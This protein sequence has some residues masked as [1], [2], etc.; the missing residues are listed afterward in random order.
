MR[1]AKKEK[2][3]GSYMAKRAAKAPLQKDRKNRLD[4]NSEP[5]DSAW[6]DIKLSFRLY[7]VW[8]RMSA[9][10]IEKRY[11]RTILGPFWAS[12][13]MTIF[14][15][16]MGLVFAKLWRMDITT[17]LP[18]LTTGFMA[19][20]PISSVIMEGASCLVASS[21]ITANLRYPVTVFAINVAVRNIFVMAHHLVVYVLIC[22]FFT[23]NINGLQ[24]LAL[25]GVLAYFL[26]GIWIS[27]CLGMLCA[28]FRDVQNLLQN[29][30]QI[31]MF[32][33]PVF[34]P[35]SQLDQRGLGHLVLVDWNPLH[36]YVDIL[37]S[38][39]LGNVPDMLTYKVVLGFTIFGWIF[40]YWVFQ[41]NRT[42][43]IYW[44]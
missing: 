17:Y 33:T 38:P 43:I 2:A 21:A 13:S 6:D 32:V 4:I 39:L 9:M 30:I 19:W 3:I 5:L 40:T 8:I 16:S 11:R 12:L 27:L 28:R 37:R 25:I 42:K 34:W 22:I 26:N 18:Y 20:I 15:F 41:K 31:S 24:I 14:I 35:P 29:I 7:P 36:H 10:D 23:V 44:A 1:S